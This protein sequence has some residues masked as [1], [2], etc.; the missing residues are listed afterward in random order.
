MLLR[1]EDD[2]RDDADD[3]DDDDDRIRSESANVDAISNSCPPA[4]HSPRGNEPTGRCL[5]PTCEGNVLAP[6]GSRSWLAR[7]R[8]AKTEK[9]HGFSSVTFGVLL[10]RV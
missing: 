7:T 6:V 3:D 8:L 2:T 1:Q 10:P 9:L 5:W 4:T